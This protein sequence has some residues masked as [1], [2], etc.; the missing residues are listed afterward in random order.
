MIRII[1]DSGQVVKQ[2]NI[3]QQQKINV[4]IGGSGV[5]FVQ[6]ITGKKVVTKKLVVTN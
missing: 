6:L 4:S 2:I 1:N 5:Y 3:Q